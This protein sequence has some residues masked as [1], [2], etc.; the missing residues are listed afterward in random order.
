[1]RKIKLY[2]YP[3][4]ELQLPDQRNNDWM[5]DGGAPFSPRGLRDYVEQVSPQEAEFFYMGRFAYSLF[6]KGAYKV[7][8]FPHFQECPERHILDLE[9]DWDSN[10][11]PVAFDNVI[12]TAGVFSKPLRDRKVCVRS[13]FH[14]L[15]ISMARDRFETYEFTKDHLKLGFRGCL[16]NHWLRIL[17]LGY[18]AKWGIPSSIVHHTFGFGDIS[19]KSPEIRD[20]EA[21]MLQNRLALCPRGVPDCSMRVYEAC[22]Y[23]CVPIVFSDQLFVGGD[24]YDMSFLYQISANADEKDLKEFLL[25]VL[26]T[27]FEKLRERAYAARAYFDKVMRPYHNNP[28]EFF[29]NY[30]IRHGIWKE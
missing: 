12:L 14:P 19:L 4:A 7:E 25:G 21:F 17:L 8:Y 29:L 30:L 2:I 15:L 1:M 18:F 26:N 5:V 27:P 3:K 6:Q 11:L 28:T 24:Y 20:Y 22:F 16:N 9:G 13:F 10:K 23:T